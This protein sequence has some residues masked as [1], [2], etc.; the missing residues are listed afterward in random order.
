MNRR[1][2]TPLLLGALLLI[3]ACACLPSC[4]PL[5]RRVP[6]PEDAHLNRFGLPCYSCCH[7]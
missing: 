7:H 1:R 5:E 4:T 3:L 6:I 2:P